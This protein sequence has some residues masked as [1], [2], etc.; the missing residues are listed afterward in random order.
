MK[1]IHIIAKRIIVSLMPVLLLIIGACNEKTD[2]SNTY[3]PSSS[4]AIT[5]FRLRPDTKVMEHLDSVFFSIDL[6]HR[7]IFNADSLPVGT[8]VK[9]LVPVIV[10]PSNISGATLKSVGGEY[11]ETINY[12]KNPTDSVDFSGDVYFTLIAEDGTTSATYRL[13]VNVHKTEPDRM[14]WDQLA[15]SQ[16][17]SRQ[18]A[19]LAQRTVEHEKKVYSLIREADSKMTLAVSDDFLNNSWN[20]YDFNPGFD[21][22]IRSFT[23]SDKGFYILSTTGEL[24][25]SEDALAWVSTGKSW[26]SI[27]GG[28]G[29]W[30]LG[31]R[32]DDISGKIVH[33]AWP[34][35]EFSETEAD[36]RFPIKDQSNFT[37]FYNKWAP[38]PIGTL[39]GGETVSG[40]LSDATW[41]FDG[42]TWAILS[43]GKIPALK[44]ALLI[45]YFSFLRT[46]A[47][48]LQTEYTTWLLIGGMDEA[49]NVNA[50]TWVSY[51]Y[52]VNWNPGDTMVDLPENLEP[53]YYSDQV[54]L[55]T[56]MS[57]SLSD[58]WTKVSSRPAGIY[59][60]VPHVVDGTVIRWDCPY[61]YTF[62]G[63]TKGGTFYPH[64]RRG[65][66]TRLTFAPII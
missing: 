21:V 50:K 36:E 20:H 57:S 45:P 16:L 38:H 60:R 23:A 40:A 28:Y 65:V 25:E 59:S 2:S 3:T 64:I 46:S 27:I 39:F 62:G 63:Y 6:E 9:R 19:P 47:L 44:G 41:A 14:M 15:V 10:Y 18:P 56:P 32:S 33:T 31:L 48:W 17:P 52:G 29:N 66:L 34:E 42:T 55:S 61:I 54:I 35:G 22:D 58:A 51:D 26:I 30:I 24:Y 49:G 53:L 7:V 12:M 11:E 4:V 1:R 37:L 13:K 43:Q 8:D 5:S